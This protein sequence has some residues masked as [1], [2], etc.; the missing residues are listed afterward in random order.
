MAVDQSLAFDTILSGG[1]VFDGSGR[2]AFTKDIGIIGDRIVAVGDLSRATANRRI[3]VSGMAVCPGFIDVHSHA[4]MTLVR[5]DHPAIL[6]PLVRQGITT[7]VG[8]NCGAGM[9]PVYPENASV[10]HTFFD[11][12]IGAPQQEHV[13]WQSFGEMLDHIEAH[14]TLLNAAILAPHG[15][16]R[17]NVMGESR[18]LASPEDLRK[19]RTLLAESLDDGA[20]GMSTGLMY[21]PGMASD[22]RELVEL[23]GELHDRGGVFTSHLRSYNSD[24]MGEALKEV[25]SVCRQAEVPVQV[26]HL[27]CI[28]NFKPPLDKISRFAVK[29]A[30][31]LNK[32]IDLRL[33]IDGLLASVMEP[34]FKWHDQGWPIGFDA[35]PT[36]AGFTHLL[37]FFPPY[38]IEGGVEKTMEKLRNPMTRARIRHSIEQGDSA[39]PHRGSDSW[40]MN[41]FRV[42]G[43]EAAF[44]MSV[45]TEKNKRWEGHNI[46]D[47]AR[48]RGVHP[49][50]AACDLLL[51]ENG[52]VLVFETV[53]Q[54]GDSFV[55]RSQLSI[56][57]DPRVSIVTDT[58]L[59]G[60]GLPSHLF[61]DCYPRFLG[62]YVREQAEIELHQAIRKCTSLP[63]SQLGIR[64][65]GH[66]RE[67]Y[68]A[69]LVIFDPKT[70]ESRSTAAAPRAFPVG[71]SMVFING[72]AVVDHEKFNPE[73]RPGRILRH[74]G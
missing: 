39:W 50:D 14:G 64:N 30:S 38:V 51:E 28:P 67:G 3:D 71:I 70:I 4:D 42:M 23:A 60:F 5:P 8:G 15:I 6:E 45:V 55:E 29:A 13:K 52:R 61:Y 59:L 11:V 69:D 66:I 35:M 12:F 31:E 74:G 7:F 2:V 56:L 16:I 33:P 48:E 26:S 21:F 25:F 44:V 53:T 41:L 72:H 9:A 43:F 58:I 46:A 49:F 17:M 63:A 18:E 22:T 27:F 19:M 24:T 62:D 37:A 36:A 54:P 10:A 47:I 68:F 40:S 32:Y 34:A 20:V 1:R 73:P 57:K 65:R